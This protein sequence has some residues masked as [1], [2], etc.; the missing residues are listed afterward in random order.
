MPDRKKVIAGLTMLADRTNDNSCEG[1]KCCK[2]AEDAIILLKEQPEIVLCKDCEFGTE[3]CGNIE[4]HKPGMSEY[5][6]DY[7]PFGWFCADGKRKED[8]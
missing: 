5:E 7:H 1:L 8:S 2:I 6:S 3:A 4:C